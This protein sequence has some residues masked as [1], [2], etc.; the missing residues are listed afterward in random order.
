M[1]QNYPVSTPMEAKASGT[2]MLMA[3]GGLL[4]PIIAL[5]LRFALNPSGDDATSKALATSDPIA[6]MT[7]FVN[8]IRTLSYV[9]VGLAVVGLVLAVLAMSRSKVAANPRSVR[10][11]AIVGLVVGL[12]CTAFLAYVLF[13]N[14]SDAQTY[15]DMIRQLGG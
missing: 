10:T 4:L 14:E 6:T 15:F 7:G 3:L 2:P 5:V 1:E 9:T 13:R 8:G 12:L 11:T